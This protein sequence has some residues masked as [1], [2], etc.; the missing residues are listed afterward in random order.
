MWRY[1]ENADW[2]RFDFLRKTL[3]ARLLTGVVIAYAF[4]ML[5]TV[6]FGTIVGIF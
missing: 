5:V 2:G 6:L 4:W 3:P 1:L